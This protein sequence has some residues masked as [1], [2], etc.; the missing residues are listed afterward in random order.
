MLFVGYAT[1]LHIE[2]NTISET[3]MSVTTIV[4][5]VVS[6]VIAVLIFLAVIITPIYCILKKSNKKTS[7]NVE[8]NHLYSVVD[9]QVATLPDIKNSDPSATRDLYSV[10]DKKHVPSFTEY[11]PSLATKDNNPSTTSDVYLW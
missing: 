9:K 7:T 1:T 6:I 5:I 3:S 4:V 10:I 2:D 11:S 8:L